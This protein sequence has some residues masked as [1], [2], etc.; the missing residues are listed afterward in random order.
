MGAV[1]A[2]HLQGERFLALS[3]GGGL[4]F[5]PLRYGG[6]LFLPF[7]CNG[8]RFLALS[9]GGGW[10]FLPLIYGGDSLAP[11]S[12][13][14]SWA[15]PTYPSGYGVGRSGVEARWKQATGVIRHAP[16]PPGLLGQEQWCPKERGSGDLA[17]NPPVTQAS[18][19]L[20]ESSPPWILRNS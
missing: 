14:N 7:T 20:S 1:P 12:S 6:V 19:P 17:S 18:V 11:R 13:R 2:L 9:Y 10:L 16:L 4:S 8:E 5:L 3:Y 15:Q